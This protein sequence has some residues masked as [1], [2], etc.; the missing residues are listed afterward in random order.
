MPKWNNEEWIVRNVPLN[1]KLLVRIYDKDDKKIVDD[2]IGEFEICNIINYHAP[3]DGHVIVGSFGRHNGRFHLS[4]DSTKSSNESQQ[5]PRYTFDGPCRYSRHDSLAGGHLTILNADCIYS[6]WKIQL[7]RISFFFPPDEHQQYKPSRELYSISLAAQIAMKQTHQVL[8]ERLTSADDLW[9]L[10]FL[11]RATQQIKPC[12]YN[13]IIDDNTWQFSEID[14]R[15]FTDFEIKHA[16]LSS[17]SE[18]V[19][20]A[21]EFHLRPKFGWNRLDDEWEL[22]FDNASGT[23]S[24]NADLLVNLKKLLLFNFPGLNVIT[25]DYKDPLLRESIEQLEFAS[26]KYKRSSTT[27]STISKRVL[28]HLSPT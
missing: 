24:P 1:A 20:Y 7:R 23:Y 21:G 27:T 28:P 14:H 13:Y 6:I 19:R 5:L 22:V 8:Y 15:S 17:C 9:K 3:L 25:Y 4:I 18:C 26:Q 12:A 11:D 2:P 16:R 10:I